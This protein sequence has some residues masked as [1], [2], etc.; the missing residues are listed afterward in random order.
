M[1]AE[2]CKEKKEKSQLFYYYD[3]IQYMLVVC[4]DVHMH[5][6]AHALTL[7]RSQF[8]AADSIN[9]AAHSQSQQQGLQWFASLRQILAVHGSYEQAASDSMSMF[10]ST[11]TFKS[12]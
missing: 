3:W 5:T 10:T 1:S 4:E 6:P 8:S 12:T 2:V 9:R 7:I 11:W